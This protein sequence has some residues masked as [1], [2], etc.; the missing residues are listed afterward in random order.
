MQLGGRIQA[1]IEVL[2][3]IE[4]RHRPAGDG[5]RDWGRAHRFAGSGD[6]AVIGNLVFDT[7]RKRRSLAA[8]LDDDSARAA[9]LGV[10][11]RDWKTGIDDLNQACTAPH[12][13]QAPND[14]ETAA[15][16]RPFPQ[17]LA[18]SIAGD[19]PEWLAPEVG[20]V[21]GDTALDEARALCERPPIDLRANTLKVPR[22][23]VLKALSRHDARETA[24]SYCGVRIPAPRA[25]MRYPNVENEAGHGRGWFEVQDEGSQV[26]AQIAD[27]Q[28]GMQVL[29]LCAGAGGKTLALA[30]AMQNK[31]QVHAYDADRTRLRRIFP[32]LQRAGVRNCQVIDAGDDGRLSELDGRMDVVFVDAPCS[33][34]GTWRRR[35]DAKWRLTDEALQRRINE[36]RQVLGAAAAKV[37][38]GGRLVYVTCSILPC[39]NDDQIGWFFSECST[40]FVV[41]DASELWN[42]QVGSPLNGGPEANFGTLLTPRSHG[43]D[44]FYVSVLERARGV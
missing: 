41:R 8:W 4:S 9:V 39:E 5:I 28:P 31:G 43:T 13:P 12:G 30:A 38:P 15:L 2:E 29:D 24:L 37:K 6:R 7:L 17:D 1:A 35:P 33:G 18:S 26:A 44:G 23:K 3:E 32:R 40:D 34:S 21:F 25:E 19:F 42:A 16:T 36:Q 11:V 10:V 27:A 14:A 22:E 20:R